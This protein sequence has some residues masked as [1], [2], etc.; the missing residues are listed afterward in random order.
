MLSNI[1]LFCII[2]GV[3][4]PLLNLL[5]G[6]FGGMFGGVC[7][8]VDIDVDVSAVGSGGGIVPFNIMCFCLF[9]VVFGSAGQATMQ[10]MVNPLFTLLFLALCLILA[11][12]AY[13]LLYKLLV[14]RLKESD[15]SAL[16]YRDLTGRTATVTLS[17]SGDSIGTISTR[18]STGAAISFRA[19]MDSDLK[20]HMPNTIQKGERVVITAVD[21]ENKLCY[22]AVSLEKIMKTKMGET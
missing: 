6:W 11:G 16:S 15:V 22:V 8:D 20:E 13:W 17:I 19:K 1:F 4:I 3:A 21:R 2:L 5:T 12:L 9:L 14:K 10:F 7:V 18:D